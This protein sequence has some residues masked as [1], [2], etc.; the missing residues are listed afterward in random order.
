MIGLLWICL[1]LF[2]VIFGSGILALFYGK[3]TAYDITVSESCVLGFIACLGISEVIHGA[4]FFMNWSLRKC[5]TLWGISLC[6]IAIVALLLFALRLRGQFR[7]RVALCK[8]YKIEKAVIP[9]AFLGILFFQMLFIY[10]T[11]PL[12]TVGD[13]TLE[14][15]QSFLAEDGIYR[16]LPLTGQGSETGL[17]LRYSILCLPTIYAMLA[18]IFGV[19]GELLVCHVIPVA[20]AGIAYMSYYYLSGILF[21]TKDF[22]KRFQFLLIISV[23]FIFTD[24][25]IF[26]NGYSILH[27]GHLG[28]SVRNLILIPYLFGVTL[29][30]CW[31]KAILCVLAEAC[32]TW[33]LWG[34]G[35][36]L[37]IM[38]GMLLLTLLERKCP[39]LRTYL[40]I[41]CRKEDLS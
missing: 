9:F 25:G 16:V 18:D 8:G 35:V 1:I 7:D 2:P 30:R 38:V 39:R 6:A 14:T 36:C 22:S 5:A 23:I 13:I 10:C 24:N 11:K 21:G 37:V 12:L 26:S 29:D 28:T 40:Q 27:G 17:P 20:M 4:G 19:D 32:I 31:W 34:M 15:V 41:F 33:T 3:N